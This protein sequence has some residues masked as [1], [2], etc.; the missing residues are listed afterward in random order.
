MEGTLDQIFS[1][2]EETIAD[3]SFPTVRRWKQHHPG[4]KVVAYFP[5]YAPVELIQAC[6]LLPVGLNGGGDRVDLHHADARFGS[7]ICSIVKTTL[8]MGLTGVLEPFDGFL[9]SGICD[10]ARNLCFVLKR[11]LPE[12]YVDFLH[13]PHNP[14]T[15]AGSAFLTHEY[16]RVQKNLE[17]LS[18][19]SATEDRLWQAIKEHNENRR[20]I[21][22]LFDCR[23]ASPHLIRAW[24]A[25]VVLRMGNFLPVTDHSSLLRRVL[26]QLPTRQ[27]KPRD[28]LRVIVEGSFCEQPPLDLIRLI[29]EAGCY[30]VDD[31]F[32][33]GRRWFLEDVPA[34]GSPLE[35]LAESYLNRS[36]A[37]SVRH[38]WRRPR[39]QV[40]VE[41]VRR[42]RA[43]AVILLIAKFCEPAYFDYV[44][45]KR[46]LE[47]EGIP[48]L[49]LEFEEKMFTFERLRTELETF[50]ES[51]IFA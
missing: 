40:L 6:G 19:Q 25:Y 31:D 7:F 37:S 15:D 23:V 30:I 35:A 32:L 22:H 29:E 46:E 51:L 41:K 24:E 21:R 20:L 34:E 26:D 44:L 27:M 38:D 2:C 16:E 12:L 18:G 45:Y 39:H 11:N 47:R 10:S 33:L 1:H 13:L 49:L 5:V 8:E 4:G 36:V 3:L 17:R 42:Y 50:V 14:M 48:H 43:D 9:F 28:S